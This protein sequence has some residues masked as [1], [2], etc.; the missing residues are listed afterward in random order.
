[1]HQDFRVEDAP[2]DVEW[3]IASGATQAHYQPPN[4]DPMRA[5]GVMLSPPRAREIAGCA[6]DCKRLTNICDTIP[7]RWK[8]SAQRRNAKVVGLNVG[9][10]RSRCVAIATSRTHEAYGRSLELAGC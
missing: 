9:Q 1:M 8:G 3:A 6:A 7:I 5:A 2:V 4:R 10:L